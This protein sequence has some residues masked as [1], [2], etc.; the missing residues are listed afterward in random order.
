MAVNISSRIKEFV[1]PR[2]HHIITVMLL[3]TP[4][5]HRVGAGSCA[6]AP[7]VAEEPGSNCHVYVWTYSG[8]NTDSNTLLKS[9]M[10]LYVIYYT[11]L[12]VIYVYILH[13]RKK[14]LK[15]PCSF[16]LKSIDT[17]LQGNLWYK[18]LSSNCSQMHIASPSSGLIY[19]SILQP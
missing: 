10:P 16:D 6:H 15:K 5:R 12:F 8:M 13:V 9:I 18:A 7:C 3:V 19:M 1:L 11:F 17:M 2:S 14:K 4:Q